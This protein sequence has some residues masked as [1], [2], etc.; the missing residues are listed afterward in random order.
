MVGISALK[1]NAKAAVGVAVVGAVLLGGVT[2][3]KMGWFSQPKKAVAAGQK[4]RVGVFPA[5]T[6]QQPVTLTVTGLNKLLTTLEKRVDGLEQGVDS[7]TET[8]QKS[9]EALVVA[10]KRLNGHEKRLASHEKILKQHGRRLVRVERIASQA[11]EAIFITS[12]MDA[13]EAWKKVGGFNRNNGKGLRN[14]A[15]QKAGEIFA[16]IRGAQQ[17]ADIAG[18]V[19]EDAWRLAKDAGNVATSARS[20]AEQNGVSVRQAGDAATQALRLIR[21][22][23][24]KK[25]LGLHRHDGR[26]ADEVG[27]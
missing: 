23:G 24:D 17:S 14:E 21:Q 3:H 20:I 6:P 18:G 2:A 4:G 9:S 7:L 26:L 11:L 15:N 27:R 19:A 16:G 25:F 8:G 13:G 12:G 5:L 22:H 1:K 10:A